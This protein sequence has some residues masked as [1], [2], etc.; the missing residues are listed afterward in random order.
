[1][2]G[3]GGVFLH[4][5]G[6]EMGQ[7]RKARQW[8]GLC[9]S[10]IPPGCL[11]QGAGGAFFFCQNPGCFPG[12]PRAAVLS[13][14]GGPERRRGPLP[15]GLL[16]PSFSKH[17]TSEPPPIPSQFPNTP[18]LLHLCPFV[19]V[20]PPPWLSFPPLPATPPLSL[21]WLP[22][23]PPGRVPFTLQGGQ[24][25]PAASGVSLAP[26]NLPWWKDCVWSLLS[27]HA[28]MHSV[29][30][31]SRF[32]THILVTSMRQYSAVSLSALGDGGKVRLISYKGTNLVSNSSSAHRSR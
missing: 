27:A 18:P 30:F 7:R 32:R 24:L 23:A 20:S 21:K 9:V 13:S 10:S 5:P 26:G 3:W 8:G 2:V 31:W 16:P 19:Q 15:E 17:Q 1:M 14:D 11:L 29:C 28:A 12:L 25:F 4:F 6:E 22:R